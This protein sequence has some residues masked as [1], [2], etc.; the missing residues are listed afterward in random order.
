MLAI[1][2]GARTGALTVAWRWE[3]GS[4][5]R[6]RLLLLLLQVEKQ[7]CYSNEFPNGKWFSWCSSVSL[8]KTNEK[9]IR[10]WLLVDNEQEETCVGIGNNVSTG[11]HFRSANIVSKLKRKT[12]CRWWWWF[13]N[14]REREEQVSEC[15]SLVYNQLLPSKTICRL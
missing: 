12:R 4:N 10:N 11:C 13:L 6:E 5:L 3:D 14:W 9:W 7:H 2:A 15:R 8:Y 1:I